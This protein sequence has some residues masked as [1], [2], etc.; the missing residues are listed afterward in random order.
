MLPPSREMRRPARPLVAIRR[1]R[2][3]ALLRRRGCAPGSGRRAAGRPPHEELEAAAV[4]LRGAPARGAGGPCFVP[5]RRT[6]R[7]RKPLRPSGSG[8][9]CLARAVSAAP[10]NQCKPAREQGTAKSLPRTWAGPRP[11]RPCRG[12]GSTSMRQGS[13]GGRCVSQLAKVRPRRGRRPQG[14]EVVTMP[15]ACNEAV[16]A[17]ARSRGSRRMFR[18]EGG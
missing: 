2:D 1:G 10:G 3:V 6:A 17:T 8:P 9:R 7:A 13:S 15:D 18:P 16:R 11:R 5:G 14:P 12:G 4:C